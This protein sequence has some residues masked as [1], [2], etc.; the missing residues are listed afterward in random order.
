MMR[1]FIY[2]VVGLKFSMEVFVITGAD[3]NKFLFHCDLTPSEYIVSALSCYSCG[4]L[5]LFLF[6]KFQLSYTEN[7]QSKLNAVKIKYI[8]K[9]L[10]FFFL[11]SLNKLTN[12][13]K[14]GQSLD[15]LT[16]Q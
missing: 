7:S 2:P 1:T 3:T 5:E 9:S 16:D 4:F 13:D 15:Q 6:S 10:N 11:Q 14:P 12:E 8:F